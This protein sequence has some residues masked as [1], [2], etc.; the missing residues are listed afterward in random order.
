M[1]R[2]GDNGAVVREVQGNL[3]RAGFPLKIDGRFGPVTDDAVRKFQKARHLPVDGVVGPQTLSALH[4]RT[5]APVRPPAQ[6]AFDPA[7]WGAWLAKLPGAIYGAVTPD[8]PPVAAATRSGRAGATAPTPAAAPRRVPATAAAA[9]PPAAAR[10]KPV[11]SPGQNNKHRRIGFP[12]YDGRGYV[13]QDFERYE[14]YAIRLLGGV[15]VAP[16]DP[17]NLIKNECAQF[18]QFFGVPQTRTWRRGPQVCF[19]GQDEIPSGTVVATLRDDRYHNDYSGRS[20]VGIYLR[21]DPAGTKGGGVLL[22]DQFNKNPIKRRLKRYDGDAGPAAPIRATG[23]R[24]NWSGD[25][26]EYFVLLTRG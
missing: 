22:L 16:W 8:T 6:D 23:R 13:L 18:V 12:G 10:G 11:V 24:F 21:H 25:G 1:I 15:S 26:E 4:R 2:K 20:H 7:A 5:V 3:R 9:P 19:L 17:R 14:G